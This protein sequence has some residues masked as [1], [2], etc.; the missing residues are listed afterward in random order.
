MHGLH[1][2]IL[3]ALYLGIGIAVTGGVDH[4]LTGQIYVLMGLVTLALTRD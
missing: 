1:D 3:G 4:A 2:R